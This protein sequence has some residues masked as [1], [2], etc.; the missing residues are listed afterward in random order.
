MSQAAEVPRVLV[1][2]HNPFSNVQNNGKTLLA[3]FEDWPRERLAQ[4]Y[5]TLD[6]PSFDICGQFYR[7]TDLDVLKDALPGLS[8]A[9]GPVEPTSW[10]RDREV[11]SSLG[12]RRFYRT[13]RKVFL[14]RPPAALMVRSLVWNKARADRERFRA[15][16]DACDPQL[17]FFQ[18]SS[19]VFAFDL[20]EEI[21]RDRQIPLIVETTDDYLTPGPRWQP[22][23]RRYHRQMQR[24]YQR[25]IDRSYAAVA[26]GDKMAGEYSERFGGRWEVAMNS[27]DLPDTVPPRPDDDSRPVVL[28]FAGNLGLNRWRVL[29]VLGAALDVLAERHHTQARLEIFSIDAPEPVVL[30][31]LTAS[32]RVS[33]RGSVDAAALHQHRSDSDVLVHVESFD[34]QNRHVTRLSVSTKIPEYMTADRVILAIGPPDVASIQYVADKDFGAVVTSPDPQRIAEELRQLLADPQRRA[35][36]RSRARHLV[37]ANHS[38]QRTKE[39]VARLAVEAVAANGPGRR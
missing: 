7:V 31:E 20:V 9:A 21:C 18:S 16:L 28:H 11:K 2:S 34:E 22:F 6:E 35:A 1:V 38:R 30:A 12:K 26:I 24:A 17:V 5:L 36:L 32:A 14:A 4:L 25:A 39:L 27:V 37:E 33:F 19:A 8:G 10:T 13:I 3:F 29:A 15:W 23:G